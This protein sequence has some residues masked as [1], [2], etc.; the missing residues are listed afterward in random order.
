M[1]ELGEWVA[2]FINS[3]SVLRKHNY[4]DPRGIRYQTIPLP[5]NVGAPLVIEDIEQL[6]YIFETEEP[7]LIE[8]LLSILESMDLSL[9]QLSNEDGKRFNEFVQ[10]FK[11]QNQQ[12]V[13]LEGQPDNMDQANFQKDKRFDS[14]KNY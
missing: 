5:G 8:G 13:R 12:M 7:R 1:G 10:S 2:R 11:K 4:P 6:R 3:S 9:L 14:N